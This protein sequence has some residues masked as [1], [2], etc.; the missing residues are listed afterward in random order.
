MPGTWC[1]TSLFAQVREEVQH[2]PAAHHPLT[3]ELPCHLH[4]G[5][6]YL[7]HRGFEL[8]TGVLFLQRET[9]QGKG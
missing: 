1:P 6:D 7:W 9:I 8:T 2:F 3:V 4:K 5:L